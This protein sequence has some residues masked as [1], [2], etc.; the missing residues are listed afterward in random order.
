M[1]HPLRR[2][3]CRTEAGQ[4]FSHEGRRYTLMGKIGDGAVGIVRKA[5]DHST[6]E[7]VAVKFLAPDPKYIEPERFDDVADRFRREGMRG[8]G[9]RHENLVRV[10]AYS[11]NAGGSCF[12]IREVKN[13][14]LIMEHV[15][16][17]TL[18]ALIRNLGPLPDGGV[19]ITRQTL[20]VARGVTAALLHLHDRKIIHR[21][22]KPANVFISSVT[23]G[24]VPSSVKVGD[25]G[26]TKWNDFLAAASTG[27]LT[28]T[29]QQGL[30]TLKYMA[31]EQALKPKDVTVRADMYSLGIT[32]F[33][34]FTGQI[35]ASPHHVYQV[36][37]ARNLRTSITGKLLTLGVRRLTPAQESVLEPI[38]EMFMHASNRPT[39]KQM[40]GR[41]DFW[42]ERIDA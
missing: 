18:E 42:L 7:V 3:L 22:I 2:A 20:S 39:S 26:I 35:L 5:R 30:G 24:L 37:A 41:F 10:Y 29:T 34:L 8:A 1:G 11:D 38:L 40:L 31:P 33:E 27:V 21:D 36:V 32:L 25:F 23:A 6:G 17:R 28:A 14:L 16:G 4:G 15:R 9:L 12:A 19:H 13:P